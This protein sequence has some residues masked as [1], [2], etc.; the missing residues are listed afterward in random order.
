MSPLIEVT[1]KKSIKNPPD[2]NAKLLF[3]PNFPAK[4]L[5]LVPF[6]LSKK[7]TINSLSDKYWA[8]SIK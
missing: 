1:V 4:A 8:E 7:V 5:Q 6:Q 3:T 2:A